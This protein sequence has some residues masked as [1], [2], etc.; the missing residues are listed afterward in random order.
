MTNFE[1]VDRFD[2]AHG[3]KI[4]NL[5]WIA[6]SLENSDFKDKLKGV[7]IINA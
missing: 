2:Q 1:A 6:G 4:E 5:Y 7:K 3:A